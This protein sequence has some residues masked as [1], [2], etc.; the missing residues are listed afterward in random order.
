MPR[1][2]TT[3]PPLHSVEEVHSPKKTVS[4]KQTIS[5]PKSVTP[6]KPVSPHKPVAPKKPVSS[7]KPASAPKTAP[8]QKTVLDRPA[9][10]RRSNPPK[11]ITS[12]GYDLGTH[13]GWLFGLG[14]FLIILGCLGLKTVVGL[15]FASMIFLGVLLVI[16]GFTQLLDVFKCKRWEPA[17]WYGLISLLYIFGGGLIIYD[18]FLAS[19][20]ITIMLA[21]IL[22]VIGLSRLMMAFSSKNIAGWGWLTFAGLI[23]ILLGAMIMLQW[24]ISGLWVIGLFIAIQLIIDGWSYLFISLALRKRMRQ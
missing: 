20:L 17:F 18:P 2:T 3:K 21:S 5:A 12:T 10:V 23:A 4:T 16:A 22:M 7:K 15:T 13:W 11:K 8:L 9:L 19:A 14:V 24:P 1:K 6:K